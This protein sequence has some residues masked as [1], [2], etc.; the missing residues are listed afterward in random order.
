MAIMKLTEEIINSLDNRKYAFDTVKHNIL[1]NKLERTGIRGEVV[2][3]W[4]ESCTENR[5][6]FV[7]DG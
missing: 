5:Q 3:K 7:S 6:Q 4:L 1:I 2:L